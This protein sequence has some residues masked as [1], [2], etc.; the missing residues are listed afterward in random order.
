[1]K[2]QSTLNFVRSVVPR[3]ILHPA[4]RLSRRLVFNKRHFLGKREELLA[5]NSTFTEQDKEAIRATSLEISSQDRM[6][7]GDI[8]HY[9][10]S[11]LSGIQV[12]ENAI[13]SAGIDTISS[14]LDLPC[15]HGRVLRHLKR[16]FP[17]AHIS[18]CDLDLHGVA[19]CE[20]TF[21]VSGVPSSVDLDSFS[22]T[23]T[24]DLIWCGSLITHFDE[25]NIR[26]LL[27]FFKRHLNPEGVI[28]FS[29][30]GDTAAQK[31]RKAGASYSIRQHS[32]EHLLTSYEQTGYGYCDYED[33]KGIGVSLTSLAWMRGLF[34]D[35]GLKE[36]YFGD[37]AW[38]GHHDVFGLVHD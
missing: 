8:A 27:T 4:H 36:S 1:M 15:G 34:S 18:A 11:G 24:F 38:D 12:V 32:L 37:A 26:S 35:L 21:N 13:A 2:P 6:Y 28:V 33:E 5:G 17:D 31:M 7:Q 25:Q 22:L 3:Q 20:S 14:V 29:S 23:N 10:R 30:H 16:K 9:F 19:F